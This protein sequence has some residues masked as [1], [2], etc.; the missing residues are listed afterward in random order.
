[1]IREIIKD[2][3]DFEGDNAFGR[4]SLPVVLGVKNSKIVISILLL[5]TIT[6]LLYTYFYHLNDKITLIYIVVAI[7][8]PILI[9]I[10]MVLK[11]IQKK[12]FKRS[13]NL[14]KFIMLTGIL[15]S[16]VVQYII[17]QNLNSF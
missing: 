13:S 5:I 10:V 6:A 3:E 2:I 7:I 11:G 1:M 14:L 4:N 8:L 12:D 9:L 16:L 15:Y 17:T